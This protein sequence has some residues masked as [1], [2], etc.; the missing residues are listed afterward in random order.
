MALLNIS[1]SHHSCLLLSLSQNLSH[2]LL[3]YIGYSD[4]NPFSKSS[5][6]LG[7]LPTH[8]IPLW[9]LL[10][11]TTGSLPGHSLNMRFYLKPTITSLLFLHNF[12]H[13]LHISLL[14]LW[15]R[16]WLNFWFIISLWP[17]FH[18]SRA[19]QC[20]KSDHLPWPLPSKHIIKTFGMR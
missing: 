5:G 19:S 17:R 8:Y 4:P 20:I 10:T 2:P 1:Q 14:T 6:S 3:S 12:N 9:G 11:V 18:S 13:P 15:L 7:S 16:N